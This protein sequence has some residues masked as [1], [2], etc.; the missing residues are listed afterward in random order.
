MPLR[1]DRL[2]L[3]T[4]LRETLKR[5]A[6]APRGAPTMRLRGDRLKLTTSLRVTLSA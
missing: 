1:G 6:G 4:T 3:T 2:K 5:V